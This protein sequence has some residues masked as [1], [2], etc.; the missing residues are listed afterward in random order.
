M[1]ELAREGLDARRLALLAR[2][3]KRADVAIEAAVDRAEA[4]LARPP[5]APGAIAFDA[6][7]YARLP[8][9]IALRLLGRAVAQ[10]RGRRPG[11]TGQAG[12]AESGARCCP[13]CRQCAVSAQPGRGHCDA[14][15]APNRGGTG[16]AAPRQ[17]L[18][19][20]ADA[21][22]PSQRNRA[23]ICEISSPFHAGPR[24]LHCER[25]RREVATNFGHNERPQR[26][27]R[28]VRTPDER[29]SAQ[30]RPLGDHRPAA[31]RA[32]HAVP[33]SRPAHDLAGHLVLAA[34]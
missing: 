4:E 31:A 13:K 11:R 24:C 8:A 26:P 14:R 25:D 33:E 15:R 22:T 5:P 18:N 16:A 10:R 21:V 6:A 9:E 27:T 29:Q 12:G 7:G 30:F 2:R 19:H 23:R 32:V 20:S 34:A 28:R 3:L 1:P 17:S